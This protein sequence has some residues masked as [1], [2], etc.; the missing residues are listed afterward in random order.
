MLSLLERYPD[1]R[2]AFLNVA[3][4]SLYEIPTM[5]HT[6]LRLVRLGDVFR[7][8]PRSGRHFPRPAPP[9]RGNTGSTP[10]RPHPYKFVD[11]AHPQHCLRLFH[12]GINRQEI[13]CK[14]FGGASA[15]FAEEILRGPA[16]RGKTAFVTLAELG[17]RIAASN[18]GGRQRAQDRLCHRTGEIFV[19][20]S[21]TRPKTAPALRAERTSHASHHPVQGT[22]T[23]TSQRMP[24]LMRKSGL[25]RDSSMV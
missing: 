2:P 9:G 16:Q 20:C 22:L 8:E 15:M 23:D 6:V 21:T 3:Q 13:E 14:V 19:A 1:H 10:P 4:G 24:S 5:A 7:A 25:A 12:R 18:V 17:L 11:T